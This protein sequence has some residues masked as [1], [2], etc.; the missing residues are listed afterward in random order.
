MLDECELLPIIPLN[1]PVQFTK[2]E[3]IIT[4]VGFLMTFWL[5]I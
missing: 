4:V 5:K 2:G 3:S 1:L